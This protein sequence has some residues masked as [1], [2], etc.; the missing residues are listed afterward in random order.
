MSEMTNNKVGF[1]VG[2]KAKAFILVVTGILLALFAYGAISSLI[3][4]HLAWGTSNEMEWGLLIAGYV[5]FAVG[6]TGICLLTTL[7]HRSWILKLVFGEESAVATQTKLRGMGIEPI[8]LAISFITAGFA[9]LAFEMA[10]PLRLAIYMPTSPNFKSAFIWMGLF[11]GI[12]LV[13]LIVELICHVRNSKLTN[14]F[15]WLAIITG[16]SAT[17][18][19]GAVFGTMPGRPF[20]TAPYLPLFFIFTALLCGAA[21]IILLFYFTNKENKEEIVKY[22]GKLLILFILVVMVFNVWN[23]VSSF[24]GQSPERFEALMFLLTGDLA[25]SFWVFEIGIGLVLPLLILLFFKS[26]T[27][28]VTSAFMVLFGMMFSRHNLIYAGQAVLLRPDLSSTPYFINY[29][30]TVVELS[31]FIGGIG[32]VTALFIVLSKVVEHFMKKGETKPK[33]N[34]KIK[35]VS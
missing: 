24:I 30:P 5:Y 15:G 16:V 10:Y 14:L 2:P 19:L 7:G 32:I 20:W 18:N 27:A 28:H 17:S 22:F 21:A 33:V 4:G 12:Y 11:Y 3:Q 23:I 31:L 35:A 25:I 1:E 26:Q 34:K 9:V 13:F 6:C 8:I 29:A